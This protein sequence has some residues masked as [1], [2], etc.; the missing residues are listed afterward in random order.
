[1]ALIPVEYRI[2]TPAFAATTFTA[3]SDNYLALPAALTFASERR[4][5][6]QSAGEAIAFRLA[7]NRT[8]D[9]STMD[10]ST[11]DANAYQTTRTTAIYHKVGH[12]FRVAFG[13]SDEI[14]ENILLARPQEGYGA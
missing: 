5:T 11:I 3:G 2:D 1:M 13:D 14:H 8:M 6:L 7:A 4:S 9:E 10:E 12:Q